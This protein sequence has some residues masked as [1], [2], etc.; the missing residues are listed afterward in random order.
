MYDYKIIDTDYYFLVLMDR[1]FLSSGSNNTNKATKLLNT[2]AGIIDPANKG[3]TYARLALINAGEIMAIARQYAAPG[4]QIIGNLAH[5][6]ADQIVGEWRDSTYGIGGGRVPL[7]VKHRPDARRSPFYLRPLIS[8]HA[9]AAEA[10]VYD[11]K[12]RRPCCGQRARA[13]R[14]A[15][16][17]CRCRRRFHRKRKS[18]GGYGVAGG[19]YNER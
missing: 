15:R 4:N 19:T 1:Y 6:K 16:A 7:D 12:G 3:L 13:G 14:K 17:I 11:T 2:M 10:K 8:R 9:I 5:L 18:L